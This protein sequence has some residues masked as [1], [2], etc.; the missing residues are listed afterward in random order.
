[1][2]TIVPGGIIIIFDR[3]LGMPIHIIVINLHVIHIDLIFFSMTAVFI[4]RENNVLINYGLTFSFS[5]QQSQNGRHKMTFYAK[6][7]AFSTC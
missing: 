5:W 3:H 1:M 2:G 6:I 4:A 7:W